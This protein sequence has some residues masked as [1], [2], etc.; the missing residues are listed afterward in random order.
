VPGV[1]CPD[2]PV[3][4]SGEPAVTRLR[5]LFGVGFTVLR[6]G[7]GPEVKSLAPVRSYRLDEIDQAGTVTSALAASPGWCAV[8]RPDGHLAAVLCQPDRSTLAAALDR[9]RGHAPHDHPTPHP[10]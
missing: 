5:E 2:G 3:R 10:P 7:G 8:V 1:L 9:A 4:V 6:H